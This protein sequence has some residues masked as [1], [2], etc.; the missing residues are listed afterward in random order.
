MPYAIPTNN[1]DVLRHWAVFKNS[2]ENTFKMN[3][4]WDDFNISFAKNSFQDKD[5][6]EFAFIIR[7]STKRHEMG[8][9]IELLSSDHLLYF[10]VR[11]TSS[12]LYD[13]R[14]RGKAFKDDENNMTLI[15]EVCNYIASDFLRMYDVYT[16]NE[17]KED[18]KNVI[19]TKEVNELIIASNNSLSGDISTTTVDL[20]LERKDKDSLSFYGI[21][22]MDADRA[23]FQINILDATS[24]QAAEIAKIMAK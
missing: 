2:L 11:S 19:F 8:L 22:H 20:T 23:I 7:G 4:L 15:R 18:A 17:R 12:S 6:N 10:K 24:E 1:Y 9:H 14:K 13:F 21:Q 16:K 5:F 3:G